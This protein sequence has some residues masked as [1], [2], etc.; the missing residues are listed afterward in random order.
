MA[1]LFIF[2]LNTELNIFSKLCQR[3]CLTEPKL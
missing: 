2:S 3:T 1:Q